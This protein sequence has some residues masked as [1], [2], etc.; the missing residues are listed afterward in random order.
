MYFQIQYNIIVRTGRRKYPRYFKLEF[1]FHGAKYHAR[2][3]PIDPARIE[4][5]AK[6]LELR[7]QVWSFPAMRDAWILVLEQRG[8]SQTIKNQNIINSFSDFR[9]AIHLVDRIHIEF[10]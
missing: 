10:R 5:H 7:S 8:I 3:R 2:P 9:R 1:A 4:L 6:V